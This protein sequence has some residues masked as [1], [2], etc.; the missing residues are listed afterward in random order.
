LL[1]DSAAHSLDKTHIFQQKMIL[2]IL[3]GIIN[4]INSLIYDYS[5]RTSK[6]S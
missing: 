2:Q 4:E 3:D 5:Q 6:L 1:I